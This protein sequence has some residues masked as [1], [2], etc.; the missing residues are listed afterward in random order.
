MSRRLRSAVAVAAAAIAGLVLSASAQATF[1]G[2]NGRI[3]FV[4]GADIHTMQPDGH[5]V[6]QLTRLRRGV[7]AFFQSW[8]PDGRLIVF[9][10]F[11][12]DA[13][14]QLWVMAADGSRQRLLLAESDFAE[15]APRFSPDGSRSCSRAVR[16]TRS[17]RARSGA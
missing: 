5:G 10:K 8:S 13:P 9:N 14:P 7:N 6:R 15:Q 17:R 11:F 3:A 2:V 1:P 12:P 4:R 16:R